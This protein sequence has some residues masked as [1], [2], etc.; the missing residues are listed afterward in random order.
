MKKDVTKR[1]NLR[2]FGKQQLTRILEQ[3]EEVSYFGMRV[4]STS[5]TLAWDG[6][7]S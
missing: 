1:I 4:S 3:A 5:D 7:E 6:A 2:K